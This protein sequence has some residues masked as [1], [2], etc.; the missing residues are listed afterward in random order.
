METSDKAV[1]DTGACPS[2]TP[3]IPRET[4]DIATR[5]TTDLAAPRPFIGS[6]IL[7]FVLFI[8]MRC[9]SYRA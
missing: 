9:P 4:A 3:A 2:S 8:L 6:P 7:I 5:E 1:L